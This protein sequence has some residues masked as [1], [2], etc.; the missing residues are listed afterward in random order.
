[1]V[2]FKFAVNGATM[3]SIYDL[4]MDR[5][6]LFVGLPRDMV[7]AYFDIKIDIEEDEVIESSSMTGAVYTQYVS[8]VGLVTGH[9]KAELVD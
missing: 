7:S 1:M 6:A 2:H 5:A 3:D 9:S 4:A 8:Y